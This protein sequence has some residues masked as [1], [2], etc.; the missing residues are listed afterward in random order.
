MYNLQGD[1]IDRRVCIICVNLG[2]FLLQQGFSLS[3]VCWLVFLTACLKLHSTH[4]FMC[5]QVDLCHKWLYSF[6][7]WDI[8][9]VFLR[10][11]GMTIWSYTV[12]PPG[13]LALSETPWFWLLVFFL[14]LFFTQACF[15]ISPKNIS[16]AV[17]FRINNFASKLVIICKNVMVFILIRLLKMYHSKYNFV[18]WNI[19]N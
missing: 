8:V 6:P 11:V 19:L 18:I 12:P 3:W 9:V 5:Q 15:C 16:M 17:K 1:K 2:I 4:T 13:M 10:P 14:F 7:P